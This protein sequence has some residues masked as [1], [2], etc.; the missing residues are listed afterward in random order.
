MPASWA[1]PSAR[2]K[3]HRVLALSQLPSA[4]AEARPPGAW[5]RVE[6][7]AALGSCFHRPSKHGSSPPAARRLQASQR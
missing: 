3:R 4:A 6:N 7:T 5:C 1:S 2:L